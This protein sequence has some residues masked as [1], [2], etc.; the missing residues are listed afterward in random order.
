MGPGPG[1]GGRAV[2]ADT[3]NQMAQPAM[4]V[5]TISSAAQRCEKAQTGVHARGTLVPPAGD[6]LAC[7]F[8]VDAMPF[9]QSV[10]VSVFDYIDGETYRATL[11][12]EYRVWT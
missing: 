11:T 12:L 9:S 8:M 6:R 7:D 2:E 5:G 4:L 3:V 10:E 1:S